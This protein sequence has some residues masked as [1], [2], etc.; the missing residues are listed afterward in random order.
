[1]KRVLLIISFLVLSVLSV[2]A[3]EKIIVMGEIKSEAN[4]DPLQYVQVFAYNTVA[5]GRDAYNEAKAYFDQKMSWVSDKQYAALSDPSGSYEV[6]SVPANGSLLFYLDPYEPVFV[7]I[8]GKKK[9]NV[10][11]ENNV[12]SEIEKEHLRASIDL[13]AKFYKEYEKEWKY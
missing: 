9:I 13:L 8:K 7:Q 2:R 5:E 12:R 4:D 3:Q 6:S 11:I 10:K 1:M